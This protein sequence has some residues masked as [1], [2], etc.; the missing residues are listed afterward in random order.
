MIESPN[1]DLLVCWFHGTG[2]RKANDVVVNGSRKK[3]GKKCSPMFDMADTPD[4]PDCNP[5]LFVDSQERLWLFWA[6]VVSNGWQHSLLRYKR[7]EK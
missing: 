3:K 6:A 5:V 7:A 4:L 1:G 2:E